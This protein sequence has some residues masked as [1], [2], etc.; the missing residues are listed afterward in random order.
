MLYL[1]R[2]LEIDN[3]F[4]LKNLPSNY[5]SK[6][7]AVLLR[8][9]FHL[10]LDGC[11]T[12]ETPRRTVAVGH[13]SYVHACQLWNASG[14]P[15]CHAGPSALGIPAYINLVRDPVERFVSEMN[16]LWFGPRSHVAML[17]ARAKARAQGVVGPLSVDA[18]VRAVPNC[19]TSGKSLY[20]NKMVDYFCGDEPEC[21]DLTSEGALAI[22][23][24]H[25]RQSYVAVGLL[26]RLPESLRL[27]ETAVPSLLRGI[28]GAYARQAVK[29][30]RVTSDVGANSAADRGA[31]DATR[32]FLRGCMDN[33]HRLYDV[34]KELF[35]ERL[36]EFR[37][38]A[39]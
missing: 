35:E 1:L 14:T 19:S 18:L 9:A 32:T 2:T 8:E 23:K 26:E 3:N 17:S 33:D 31:S 13:F 21:A 4:A 15:R 24:T 6:P 34:V 10:G 5:S 36:R 12:H 25:A 29:K 30:Q 20:M 39:G 28:S 16:Y 38:P 11:A 22:A 27:F 37:L 7:G